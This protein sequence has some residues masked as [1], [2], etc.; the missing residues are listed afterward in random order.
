[1]SRE[2]DLTKGDIMGKLVKLALPIMGT[3][4][5]QM[6]YNL[7]DIIWLGRLNTNAVAAAGTAG[8][9]MWFASALIMISQVGVA[10]NVAHSY[11]RQ[12][13]EGARKYISNGFKLDILIGISYSILL[14][15]FRHRIIGFFNL[16][17]ADVISMAVDYLSIISAG[18]IFHF[19]NPIFSASLNSSGNSITPFKINTTGLVFNIIM[20]PILI[21][22]VGPIPGMG[23]KGA[24][25]ATI[26]AQ[27]VVTLLF[28]ISGKMN[29][30][31]YS[32]V[33]L[34]EKPD[35][36]VIHSI[37]KIGL[38]PFGQVGVH[39]IIAMITTRIIAG[40]GATAVAV[41]NVGAQIESVSWM[42]SEGFS[43]AIAA[44]VG[45][46]YGARKLD[47]IK[48]GYKKGLSI[49][50]GIG[51]FATILLIAGAKPLF[52]IFLPNDPLAI[53]EGINYLRIIGLCQLFMTI[54]IGTAGAFNGIGR[55][56]PPTING[57]F[58]NALRIPTAIVL[59]GTFLGLSGVWWALTINTILKGVCIYF[60]FR[61]VL[62][63][64][65]V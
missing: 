25:L 56:L 60:M 38:P 57:A 54:E 32:H 59:S 41:Q 14:F 58:W 10:V 16:E 27:M 9:F 48:E 3:S 4:F 1:M 24:A 36:E 13:Y 61:F 52:T 49:L 12:D 17:D 51:I 11:G 18:I 62:R 55:T 39:A 65:E 19:V 7:T 37:M 46:N 33:K 44:F 23:I 21:F 45:Q 22:G 40:F 63:K 2:A 35:R 34:I 50:I 43:S 6:A 8:F 30:S 5:I 47:R 64:L 31:I 29:S 42:T 28:I 15:T 26:M 20:D 53:K